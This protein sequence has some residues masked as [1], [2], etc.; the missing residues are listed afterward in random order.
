[1]KNNCR[2]ILL[3]FVAVC[4]VLTATNIMLAIHLAGHHKGENHNPENCPI[5]REGVINKTSAIVESAPQ[6]YQ[7]DEISFTISYSN[8]FSPQ[9]I[10]FQFPPLRA[11]PVFC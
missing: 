10:D 4:F 2:K 8:F 7:A 9:A 5:C 1:M 11:P 6:V 3:V